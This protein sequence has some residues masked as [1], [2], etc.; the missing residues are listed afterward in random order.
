MNILEQAV[1][2]LMGEYG[3]GGTPYFDALDAEIRSRQNLILPLIGSLPRYRPIAMQGKF[4]LIVY[5]M[6]LTMF[7]NWQVFTP[8][9][10]WLKSSPRT[11]EKTEIWMRGDFDYNPVF[12]DDSMYSGKTYEAVD[13]VIEEYIGLNVQSAHV[14]YDG[15]VGRDISVHSFFRYYDYY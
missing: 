10:I 11:G 1:K 2:S 13:R 9:L 6:F 3:E 15:M 8:G 14:I 12:I 7:T 4:G 5:N